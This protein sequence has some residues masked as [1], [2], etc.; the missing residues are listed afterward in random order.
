MKAQ[1]ALKNLQWY[2]EKLIEK[3]ESE[4]S[5]DLNEKDISEI[6]LNICYPENITIHF[7]YQSNIGKVSTFIE[8]YSENDIEV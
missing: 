1:G 5:K 7:D 3:Q 2:I 4:M 8:K 6:N